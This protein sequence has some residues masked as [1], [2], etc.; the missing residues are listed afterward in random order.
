MAISTLNEPSEFTPIYHASYFRLDS[1]LKGNLNFKY[2]F[3]L[4]VGANPE[5]KIRVS[6]E[7]LNGYGILDVKQHLL[8]YLDQDTFDI[9]DADFQDAP[10]VE[11]I[12]K[13]DEEYTDG[14]G[15][16]VTNA[17]V[18]VFSTKIGFNTR[19][20][21]NQFFGDLTKLQIDT[22]SPGELLININPLTTVYQ[23]DVFFL[24]FSGRLAPVFK[25]A[26]LQIYELNNSGGLLATTIITGD[27]D[28]NSQLVTM[29]LSA[30]VFNANTKFIQFRLINVDSNP[31]TQ[32][33]RLRVEP[34][35]CSTYT[36]YKL[37]YLD[38]KG[39]YNSI[40]FD[41][42][43][44]SVEKTKVQTFR[45]FINPLT[46][47]ELSRGIQRFFQDT[48]KEFT[49]NSF[50]LDDNNSLM[51]GD[52]IRSPRVFADLR[53]DSRFPNM[54]FAPVE[55]LTN[56]FRELKTENSDLIQ[57]SFDIRFAY[58]QINR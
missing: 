33:I 24:H 40:N 46:D 19:L 49:L 12:L 53:N 22:A 3:K 34:R 48:E 36:P 16:T 51:F 27:L 21:R 4:T 57:Y 18:K 10:R 56:T 9:T 20:T 29:D 47:N 15:N 43:S 32:S 37:I 11:Y 45:K 26:R 8:D 31:V 17:D 42:V 30:I 44:K 52:L 54:D 7:P 41:G 2:V 5:R 58:E 50:I 38:A 14:G 55:V 1:T 6:P 23:D 13:I 39:S 25:P 35:P 28:T